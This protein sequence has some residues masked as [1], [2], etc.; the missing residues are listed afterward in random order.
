MSVNGIQ[1]SQPT[2]YTSTTKKAVEKKAVETKNTDDTGVVYEPSS[3]TE[4]KTDRSSKVTDYQN[5]IKQMKGELSSKNQQLQNL[6][7]QLLSKQAKK[8]N[9]LK[10][11]FTDIKDGKVDVDPETVAQAQKDVAEDGYWGVNKTSD[12]LVDM[13]KAL[14]G[15]DPAKADELIS[16]IKKGFDQAADAWGGELPEI[17]QKTIDVAV[18]KL[19]DWKS[20]QVDA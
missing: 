12:R 3:T 7:D 4:S 8:Y 9:T 20:G 17:C 15:G 13:A 5:V 18:K 10:D 6:V 16:A 2:T 14:S 11:L 19:N 1:S